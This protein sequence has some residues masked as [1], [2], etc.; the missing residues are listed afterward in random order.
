MVA[1]VRYHAPRLYLF[2]FFQIATFTFLVYYASY[3]S[4]I[5][6]WTQWLNTGL[7]KPTNVA[8]HADLSDTQRYHL[9]LE[10]LCETHLTVSPIYLYLPWPGFSLRLAFPHIASIRCLLWEDWIVFGVVIVPV[11]QSFMWPQKIQLL[12]K[13]CWSDL[14]IKMSKRNHNG[15]TIWRFKI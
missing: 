7:S 15:G 4:L 10:V 3:Y 8:F 11:R 5:S 14:L 2:F 6:E 1:C 9:W 12:L 13:T